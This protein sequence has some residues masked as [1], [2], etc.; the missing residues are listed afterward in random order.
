LQRTAAPWRNALVGTAVALICVTGALVLERLFDPWLALR[1]PFF[2]L[3]LAT[4][5]AAWARGTWAGALT[6]ILSYLIAHYVFGGSPPEPFV[7]PPLEMAAYALFSTLL[8]ALA[9]AA[10]RR[11]HTVDAKLREPQAQLAHEIAQR[12]RL[13][14]QHAEA[15]KR[16]QAAREEAEAAQR[17]LE[18]RVEELETLM[19]LIPIGIYVAH[20]RE[21]RRITGNRAAGALLSTDPRGNLS[22]SAPPGEQ[23]VR[24]HRVLQNGR[25]LSLHELPL[26]RA[27]REGTESAG[28]EF[29]LAFDGG[30]VTHVYGF[31]SPLFDQDGTAR[32]AI[33]ALMDITS[34]KQ[35]EAQLEEAHARISAIL[36]SITDA[37]YALDRQWR[38]TYVNRQA[39]LYYGMSKDLLLG[40]SI[41]DVFPA[42]LTSEPFK[43]YRHAMEENVPVH[44]ELHS[45][46]TRRWIEVH[47]YPSAQGLS[48]FF[49]DIEARKKSAHELERL[50]RELNSRIGELE[51]LLELLPVGVWIGNASCDRLVGN[52]AAY[53]IL[54]LPFGINASL[55]SADATRPPLSDLQFSIDG[56]PVGAEALPMHKVARTGVPCENIEYE[57][58]RADGTIRGV[59]GS[60]AP[61][62]DEDGRVRAVIGAHTDITERKHAEM[63]LR[64]ADRRKDEFLATLAHELRNPLNP[65]R[66]AV[67]ILRLQ[68]ASAQG[69]Q[70]PGEVI[71][72][73]VRQMARL[74]DDLLDVSRITLNRLELRKQRTPLADIVAAALETSRPLIDAS[75][76]VLEIE[77]PPEPIYLDADGTRLAQVFSNLLNNSAKYTDA[78]GRIEIAAH[79]EPHEAVIVV[80]DNGIGIAPERLTH[81]FDMFSQEQ[82]A[83]DRSH[84][85]LGIGLALSRAV[86][87]LHGGSIE[88]QSDGRG[89]GSRFSVRL[90]RLQLFNAHSADTLSEGASQNAEPRRILVVDDNRDSAESLA[91]YLGLL[92]HTVRTAHDGNEALIAAAAFHPDIILLDIGLPGQNG[93]EVARR[94]RSYDWGR[95]LLLIAITGWGQDEDKRRAREH[96]FDIH[97]TKPVDPQAVAELLSAGR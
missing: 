95:G 79:A 14:M 83:L 63:A 19:D 28:E 35:T 59:L 65:I 78:G 67:A 74:L 12:E 49:R 4:A 44:F 82:P 29:E 86:V 24:A 1:F 87:Q 57:V 97:L 30:G 21:C 18:E 33:A 11:V 13:E 84:S 91:L 5:V 31:A 15:V 61:L 20:D 37:F 53:E 48:V 89:H 80:T 73:Q 68:T 93:Y 27:A 55:S 32:G 51:T 66:S 81:V 2:A 64:Q 42:L 17:Q 45:P 36:E 72:R 77:L 96:G 41:W 39:E 3:F 88:A 70:W 62:F 22:R 90:P 9:G 54:G 43:Q 76:H 58:T 85:G 69:R 60:A 38:Y 25:E 16:E 40:R 92:G 46:T 94:I 10:R 47:A 52:R 26:Q 8:I 71:D 50:H 6:A 75:G 56:G 34:R 7:P 23:Q